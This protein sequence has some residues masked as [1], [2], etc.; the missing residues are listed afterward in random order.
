MRIAFITIGIV[1]FAVLV[2][3]I[4]YKICNKAIEN[5]TKGIRQYKTMGIICIALVAYFSSSIALSIVGFVPTFI[6]IE[7]H[8]GYTWWGENTRAIIKFAKCAIPPVLGTMV[9]EDLAW[10]NE[11]KRIVFYVLC[12][13]I[14]VMNLPYCTSLLYIGLTL[15]VGFGAIT[16]SRRIPSNKR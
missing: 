11:G 10:V 16:A 9:A 15:A 14:I 5:S 3:Y 1:L 13:V 4:G 2:A 6:E 12:G 7:I 8:R